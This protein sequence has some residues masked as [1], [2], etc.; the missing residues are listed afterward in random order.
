MTSV[1]NLGRLL[2]C[3]PVTHYTD[4]NDWFDR[5]DEIKTELKNHLAQNTTAHWLEILEAADIWCA[6]VYNWNQLLETEGFQVLDMLQKVDQGD[7][8]VFE[9]SRCPI[10]IDGEHLKN[11]KPAPAIGAQ[12]KK[13]HME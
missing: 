5:Q 6:Q 8:V 7:G 11:E 4:K 9:T 10:T 1:P 13:Y 12:N 2:G 3:E